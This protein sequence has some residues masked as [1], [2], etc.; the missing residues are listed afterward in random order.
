M[1]HGLDLYMD[2]MIMNFG[3]GGLKQRIYNANVCNKKL[4]TFPLELKKLAAHEQKF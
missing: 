2:K 4:H 1:L 3:M